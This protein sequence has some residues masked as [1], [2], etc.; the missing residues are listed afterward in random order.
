MDWMPPADVHP[1]PGQ[2]LLSEPFLDDP[3]FGR[4]V[5]FLCDHDEQGSLGIVLNNGMGQNLTSLLPDAERWSIDHEVHRGGPVHAESLFYLHRLGDR[6]KGSIPVIPGLWLGGEYEDLAV[7]MEQG[8]VEAR[9]VRFFAGYSG[10]GAGQ[11]GGEM[12]LR[13]WYVH[14]QSLPGKVDT[15]MNSAPG[16]LWSSMLTSKGGGFE[17]VTS[18]PTDPSLN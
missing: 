11:L 6:V 8:G 9:D 15:V 1:K 2:F 7:A 17:R 18:W 5:V 3:W 4:K 16:E 13:S 10:W 14:D 12:K